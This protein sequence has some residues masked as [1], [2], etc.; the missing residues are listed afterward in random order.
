MGTFGFILHYE[1]PPIV[2]TIVP[3]GAAERAGLRQSDI[4]VAVNGLSVVHLSHREVVSL[5]NHTSGSSVWLSVCEP[6]NRPHH[7]QPGHAHTGRKGLGNFMSQ[8]SPALPRNAERRSKDAE[9]PLYSLEADSTPTKTGRSGSLGR[10]AMQAT[11]SA[12]T[13][14]DKPR[15]FTQQQQRPSLGT[16]P[17]NSVSILVRYIGPVEIPES[18]SS[19]GLSSKCIKEC[20]RRL[21]SKRCEFMEVLL[22]VNLH[23]VKVV[24]LQEVL[25]FKHKRE[26][27][28]YTGMCSDDEQYFAIVTRKM[29]S[30]KAE[31]NPDA[32]PRAS[33][34]HV[35]GIIA[36]KSVLV[37]QSIKD[38]ERSR[39]YQEL[40][41]RSMEISSCVPVI[42]AIKA[43]YQGNMTE[44]L[45]CVEPP[46]PLGGGG[47]G[48]GGGG[49]LKSS[50]YMMQSNGSLRS[51]GGSGGNEYGSPIDRSPNSKRR[52]IG[53]ID[54]R[55]GAVLSEQNGL[56]SSNQNFSHS[57]RESTQPIPFPA[58]AAYDVTKN[59]SGSVGSGSYGGRGEGTGGVAALPRGEGEGQ[60]F[61]GGRGEGQPFQGGRSEVQPAYGG[62][63][64]GQPIQ[65]GRSEVQPAYGGRGEVQS[66][67][68]PTVVSG[69]DTRRIS[70]NSSLSS[71]SSRCSSPN[72]MPSHRSSYA[73]HSSSSP[74][75]SPPSPCSPTP[76]QS[77]PGPGVPATVAASAVPS[78]LPGLALE[79]SY[80][81]GGLIDH[82][83]MAGSLIRGSRLTLKR[84]GS[85]HSVLDMHD[86]LHPVGVRGLPA[87][88]GPLTSSIG[89]VAT[90]HAVLKDE[91]DEAGRVGGWLASFDKL[92]QDP[93]GLQCLLQ[94]MEKEHCDEN[95]HFWKDVE[96]FKKLQP[97]AAN[98]Q[99]E[100]KRIYD[101]FVSSSSPTTINVED[102]MLK[103]IESRLSNPTPAVFDEAQDHIYRLMKMD[104]YPRFKKSELAK[105]CL[106]AEME[107]KPLPVH[108]DEKKTTPPAGD[109]V[110]IWKKH[111]ELGIGRIL[112]DRLRNN[113]GVVPGTASSAAASQVD[114]SPKAEK[115]KSKG[116]GKRNDENRKSLVLKGSPPPPEDT[117]QKFKEANKKNIF[118]INLPNRV[119][120]IMEVPSK[121]TIKDAI[122]P[123]F[124][125]HGYSF[126]IMEL[127]FA[128]T[129]R[130]VELSSPAS[131]LIGQHI[132]VV[133]SKNTFIA[134]LDSDEKVLPASS[135]R[136]PRELVA[137]LL[138]ERGKLQNFAIYMEGSSVPLDAS[139][140]TSILVG[141]R[142][143]VKLLPGPYIKNGPVSN[144]SR[145]DGPEKEEGMYEL[146]N[147]I[148]RLTTDT[149]QD[150][151]SSHTPPQTS[152][153]PT[154]DVL[155]RE[156]LS[157]PK[158]GDQRQESAVTKK[159]GG[160][161]SSEQILDAGKLMVGSNH[162]KISRTVSNNVPTRTEDSNGG[163]MRRAVSPVSIP[164]HLPSADISTAGTQ[165]RSSLAADTR[166][167]S[168][169]LSVGSM[170]E[171][172]HLG[173]KHHPLR[174]SRSHMGSSAPQYFPDAFGNTLDNRKPTG[175]APQSYTSQERLQLRPTNT[176]VG[177]QL[178]AK[179]SI[180][181][182]IPVNRAYNAMQSAPNASGGGAYYEGQVLHQKQQSWPL[183][184]PGA[185]NFMSSSQTTISRGPPS[186]VGHAVSYPY[187]KAQPTSRRP[188][189]VR[190]PS[191]GDASGDYVAF[192]PPPPSPSTHT[193]VVPD[194]RSDVSSTTAHE[195]SHET[196]V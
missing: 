126:D 105:Q 88:N 60:S 169:K 148:C 132:I 67:W 72:K 32:I 110:G 130:P 47:G 98:L 114:G 59:S 75:N 166:G 164:F 196:F 131:D 28:Y 162:L 167:I 137:S 184:V 26:E 94:F 142:V 186:V 160:S 152:P 191:S 149:L 135:N 139:I 156:T 182:S 2:G 123:L 57:L 45:A 87:K 125:K 194:D 42:N 118:E 178:Q 193:L 104:C 19:R 25:L 116:L 106:L 23:T 129:L 138:S 155:Q 153:E 76:N 13:L 54:L 147:M 185:G 49:L 109:G 92:I 95:I 151:R 64:E 17:Y 55:P 52:Q 20:M 107:G 172:S 134:V 192:R 103:S 27:L 68:R 86:H 65:G 96:A 69:E 171:Q 38:K 9:I 158:D 70:D 50:G 127:R 181:G 71:Y 189:H 187:Q 140:D 12:F 24:N 36:D 159:M 179:R 99:A 11:S 112:W 111:R 43:L 30:K 146:I 7:S 85:E 48:G 63:G 163:P 51:N 165:A 53:V 101:Q 143:V 90:L 108:M 83:P 80:M 62:R 78:R 22:D 81:G 18:W 124:K 161:R 141:Q 14:Q 84:Q 150:Q 33:M 173:N 102:K 122:T 79:T 61:Q 119:T 31:S 10:T 97:Q 8:S 128:N 5:I 40:K 176:S 117:L 113:G 183:A 66:A 82:T 44:L 41:P 56:S 144:G 58:N 136:S 115:K 174:Q 168:G 121:G 73:S 29:D 34:C 188:E 1:K 170:D 100:A 177:S 145:S 16:P 35:F 93:L 21:L 77:R 195:P 37:L 157:D 74:P 154:A 15:G 91:P 190:K 89:S 133:K 6:T 3:G 46:Q 39:S 180:P 4:V 175:P 120:K